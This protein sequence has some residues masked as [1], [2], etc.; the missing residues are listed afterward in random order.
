MFTGADASDNFEVQVT[1]AGD[2]KVFS[3]RNLLK[4]SQYDVEW[5]KGQLLG[6]GAYG[7]VWAGLNLKV[8][9]VGGI[10][11]AELKLSACASVG[12]T[13]DRCEGDAT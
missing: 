9:R 7:K 1:A 2:T 3:A 6:K 4:F 10:G 8:S 13:H 5:K 11:G 12:R